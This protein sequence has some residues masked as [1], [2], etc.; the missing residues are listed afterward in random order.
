MIIMIDDVAGGSESTRVE[1]MPLAVVDY[2][3]A[4]RGA[5]PAAARRHLA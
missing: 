5:E 3:G 2:C 4:V 1:A